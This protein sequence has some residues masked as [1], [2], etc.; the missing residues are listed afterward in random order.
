MKPFN[1]SA[2]GTFLVDR[3]GAL[4]RHIPPTA[5]PTST[6]PAVAPAKRTATPKAPA[7]RNDSSPPSAPAPRRRDD[8]RSKE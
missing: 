3:E 8:R 2:G 5:V 1:R 4:E 7:P 6:G